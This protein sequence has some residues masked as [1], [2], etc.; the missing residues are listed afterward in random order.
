MAVMIIQ[1]KEQELASLF[2]VKPQFQELF[3]ANKELI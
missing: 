2:D 1:G 3:E